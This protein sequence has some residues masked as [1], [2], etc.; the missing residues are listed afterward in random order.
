MNKLLCNACLYASGQ[1]FR[2]LFVTSVSS[3]DR[4]DKAKWG[5]EGV[6]PEVFI[7]VLRVHVSIVSVQ[8]DERNV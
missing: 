5:L 7:L 1:A 2:T 8:W 3:I 6:G 4:E